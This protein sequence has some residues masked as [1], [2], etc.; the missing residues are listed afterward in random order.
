MLEIDKA[1]KTV[2]KVSSIIF[3][4][5]V[6]GASVAGVNFFTNNN[7]DLMCAIDEDVSQGSQASSSELESQIEENKNKLKALESSESNKKIDYSR[8]GC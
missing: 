1:I 8:L 2:E 3:S 7:Q 6:L 4:M 5:G